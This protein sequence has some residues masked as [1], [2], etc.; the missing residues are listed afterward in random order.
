[1]AYILLI[2]SNSGPARELP[3][4]DG[5]TMIGRDP[6]NAVVLSG[7]GVSRRH[8]KLI[9]RQ[10]RVTVVDLGS[11][12]GT[13]I[14]DMP[15]LRREVRLDDHISIGMHT[16]EIHRPTSTAAI[17]L[18]GDRKADKP[19]APP[20]VEA[21]AGLDSTAF[22]PDDLTYDPSLVGPTPSLDPRPTNQVVELDS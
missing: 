1:M 9:C 4:L 22:T 17:P 13:K 18:R 12:Y 14:N 20:T 8:A 21:S 10:D 7:R 19:L 2:R 16:L 15:T 5:E 3:L 6:R 11:T